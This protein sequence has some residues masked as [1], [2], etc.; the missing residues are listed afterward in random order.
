MSSSTMFEENTS[1]LEET[2]D[3]IPR[4]LSWKMSNG[5]INGDSFLPALLLDSC[6]SIFSKY[7]I[8]VGKDGMGDISKADIHKAFAD[9]KLLH[10]KQSVSDLMQYYGDKEKMDFAEFCRMVR[11]IRETFIHTTH[12]EKAIRTENVMK[13]WICCGGDK[14]KTK[15]ISINELKEILCT[16]VLQ[17]DIDGQLKKTSVDKDDA[18]VDFYEFQQLFKVIKSNDDKM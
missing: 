13:A 16:L 14:D 7:E 4:M 5:S 9:L 12:S 2:M 11:S 3:R 18:K 15:K 17:F 8:N 1:D 6:S 10:A